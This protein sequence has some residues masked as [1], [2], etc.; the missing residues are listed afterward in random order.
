MQRKER[1]ALW[2][3]CQLVEGAEPKRQVVAKQDPIPRRIPGE[4]PLSQQRSCLPLPQTGSA[5]SIPGVRCLG[6][7]TWDW[8]DGPGKARAV[9]VIVWQLEAGDKARESLS[10]SCHHRQLPQERAPCPGH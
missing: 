7:G 5:P 6:L 8:Q 2:V 3:A 1:W 9:V 4:V 10:C